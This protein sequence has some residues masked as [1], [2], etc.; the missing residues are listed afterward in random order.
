MV[1]IDDVARA[2]G[3]STATVSR[4]LS[5]RGHVSP[6]TR[7]RVR[8]AAEVLGYVVSASAS[9]LASGR[10]RN[11]GVLL[12]YV[13]RW[14]FSTV[15]AGIAAELM[16]GGYDIT[17]YS[18]TDDPV[19]RRRV[20]ETFVRRQR[21]DGVICV[22][23]ALEEEETRRLAELGLPLVALG[24]PHA[25]MTTLMVDDVAI[26]RFAAEHLLSLGHRRIAHIGARPEFDL[27]FH[28]PAQRR[29]GFEQAL[30]DA[31]VPARADL[32][33]P[34][35]FTVAGGHRAATRLLGESGGGDAL[36]GSSGGGALAGSGGGDGSGSGSSSRAARRSAE[37]IPGP[38]ARAAPTAIL[39]ASDEMAIGALLAARDLGLRVPEDVSILGVDG[40][41]LGE[42]FGLTTIDQ[43]PREQG[44][45]AAAAMLGV[46]D[47]RR[48]APAT[49]T[50]ARAEAS[51]RRR[52]AGTVAPAPLP[53]RLVQRGSTGPAPN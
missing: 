27:D 35:D 53:F 22:S 1:S 44:E 52:G 49:G 16:R 6:V 42:F 32:F 48:P 11:I 7:A 9:S 38:T 31:A 40:H 3:V 4:A 50:D 39:A 19:E 5:G 29:R 51:R 26:G 33:E 30:Q 10:A 23:I 15:L 36:A 20:F 2:A 13:D 14:F 25:G 43:G 45:R 47:P 24:G 37:S 34:A 18:V 21:V 28:V 8:A 41:E 17:L 12:P 46:L